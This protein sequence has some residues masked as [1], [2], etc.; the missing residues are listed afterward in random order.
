MSNSVGPGSATDPKMPV[1][2]LGDPL[3]EGAV[4]RL[5]T[6]RMTYPTGTVSFCYLP[7]D[8]ALV[9]NGPAFEV[10]DLACGTSLERST[11]NS[12]NIVALA[13]DRTATRAA[14]VTRE[15]DV[16][17]WNLTEGREL[18]RWHSG[19]AMLSYVRISPDGERVLTTGQ[20][21]PTLKE[22]DLKSGHERIAIGGPRQS[23]FLHV[24]HKAEGA[25][26]QDGTTIPTPVQFSMGIYGPDGATAFVGDCAQTSLMHY[27]L[28]T[29]TLLHQWYPDAYTRQLALSP[30]GERLLI[31]SRHRATEWA[32]DG[33]RFLNVFTG[34][35]GHEATAVAYCRDP[36]QILTGS[37]DGSVRLW[38][39]L[40][41]TV[42]LRWVAHQR[43]VAA[44]AVSPDH[45]RCLSFGAG[46]LVESDLETG[47][48]RL[49]WDRHRAPVLAVAWLPTKGIESEEKQL[50]SSS[51]DG[52]IRLWNIANGG[53]V[54][55]FPLPPQ[56]LAGQA[57]AVTPDGRRLAVGGYAGIWEFDLNTEG[58]VRELK[59]HR[60]WVRALA[61]TP[62]GQR[63]LS[64]ADDGAILAWSPHAVEAS[65]RL[66]G[67]RGGVLA[68][69]ISP[70]GTHALSGGRDGTVRPW[71]L[72]T[73]QP[74][75]TCVGHEG[76]VEAVAFGADHRHVYSSGR[77]GRVLKWNMETATVSCEM[78]HGCWVHALACSRDGQTLCSAGTDG[79]IAL[80]DA[81][82]GRQRSC[83]S[84][85]THAVLAVA[86]S[87]DGQ[88]MASASQDNT[89]LIWRLD[90]ELRSPVSTQRK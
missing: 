35:H 67:H 12:N 5:G 66:E 25:T 17:I 39:R 72:W 55:Q 71:D 51:A 79:R 9:A 8:R 11:I 46:S 59:G 60:G 58:H 26:A 76:W 32:I 85:H 3:P 44:I 29:G 31:G 52:T 33:Y 73:Q 87:H 24:Y 30:D 42:K 10:L 21:P 83:L 82:S 61:Y 47:K 63:L 80:W 38:N 70:E 56:G 77:D 86:V 68:L 75:K 23:F 13:C 16:V 20:S 54:R 53:T 40:D 19:Q 48:P 50:V 89:L 28:R 34:H 57:L 45:H 27:D 15:G 49:E 78:N 88:H 41:S 69:A 6:T 1:D 22:W 62:D 14:F 81:H 43:Y 18:R 64:S 37:R 7:G 4:Q 90:V 36:G 2:G 84:G 65:A 74:L